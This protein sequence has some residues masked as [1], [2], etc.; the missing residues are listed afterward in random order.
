M[1]KRVHRALADD[2]DDGD[3]SSVYDDSNMMDDDLITPFAGN[4]INHI[5]GDI[6]PFRNVIKRYW[7]EE[8]V[9]I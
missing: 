4:A 2:E 6:K 3:T 8:E 5:L 9:S 7:T 1:G